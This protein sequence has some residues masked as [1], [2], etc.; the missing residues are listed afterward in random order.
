M[1]KTL[2]CFLC[3]ALLL[4]LLVSC[5]NGKDGKDGENESNQPEETV[6]QLDV[7]TLSDYIIIYP[8][9]GIS[10]DLFKEVRALQSALKETFGAEIDS[11]D[12]F[13]REG[14]KFSVQDR[15]ILVGE[16]NRTESSQVYD[17]VEKVDDYEVRLVG[18]KIV[19]AGWTEATLITALQKL[20]EAVKALPAGSTYFFD[21]TMQVVYKGNYEMKNLLLGE[22]GIAEYTVVY[23]NNTPC[24][25]FAKIV[26]DAIKNSCGYVLNC[27]AD[28]KSVDGKK[29]LIGNTSFGA[30]ADASAISDTGY[31][32][33]MSG[34]DL[35]LFGTED[36]LV[37]Q[38]VAWLTDALGAATGEVA[39]IEP[40]VG[41]VLSSDTSMTSMSFNL[42]VNN[43]TEER[44]A[45][46][47]SMIRKYM[48]DTLGVQE[49]SET[50]ISILEVALAD[51]YAHVGIGRDKNGSGE[52]SSVFYKKDKFNLVESGT[53]WLS[54]TPDQVSK[55]TGSIC[56]RVFSYAVLERKSDGVKFMHINTHTDHATDDSI[57]LAQVKALI[58][59]VKERED[60]MAI[61]ISGDFNSTAG[62]S[63]ISYI[64]SSNMVNTADIA[65]DGDDSPTFKTTVIDYFF[66]TEN[67]F[68]VYDY[69]VDSSEI[70]GDLP[71][72]HRPILIR[73]DVK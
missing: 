12:D 63:S 9:A 71:S 28:G 6:I 49:A 70:D 15:E 2:L 24:E 5:G 21:S 56:N 17:D 31:Y 52:R 50:W 51:E 55:V 36:Y 23:Q 25:S 62:T 60:E 20:T 3:A 34:D 73:Y 29:I 43:I 47:I 44:A 11:R 58:K 7:S 38:A 4:P 46:V 42:L 68:V 27:V 35:Y 39:V 61:L 54:D 72:D 8:E 13:V 65:F 30:P 1:K 26:T 18:E 67:D 33:G 41:A 64:L 22:I 16:T 59:F 19:L 32:V 45:R 14:S 37:Y 48:P 40:N 66:A 57:R 69:W 10:V 53:K